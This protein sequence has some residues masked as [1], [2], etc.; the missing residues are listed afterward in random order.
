MVG[1]WEGGKGVCE[2]EELQ[3]LPIVTPLLSNV[4]SLQP[5]KNS[6]HFLACILHIAAPNAQ[7][8]F[9]PTPPPPRK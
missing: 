2:R 8:T 5:S 3:W 1:R 6:H 7:P 9:P 4:G